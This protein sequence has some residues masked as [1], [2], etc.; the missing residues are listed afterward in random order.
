MIRNLTKSL[1][2]AVL[3]LPVVAQAMTYPEFDAMAAQDRQAYLDFL[4]ECSKK[5]MIDQGHRDLAAKI[6][7]LF[8][9][10]HPGSHISVGEGEYEMNLDNGRV[11]DA[12]KRAQGDNAIPV[13]VESALTGTL[14][15]NGF[16]LTPEFYK[17]FVQ[18]AGTFKPK[19][20]PH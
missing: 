20:P 19:Y 9:E 13:Q 17:S 12:K 15:N 5:V 8:N 18:M 3:L 2:V 4:V 11:R 10:V 14:K 7:Q 6:Y 16:V 1:L